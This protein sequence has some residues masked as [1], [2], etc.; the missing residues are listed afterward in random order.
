MKFYPK[1]ILSSLA[2]D[3]D[4]DLDPDLVPDALNF[5]KIFTFV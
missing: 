1:L 2:Q 3:L 5:F 4:Q